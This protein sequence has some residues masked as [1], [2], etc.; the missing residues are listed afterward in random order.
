[1]ITNDNFQR[2]TQPAQS[3]LALWSSKCR[4][5]RE[6]LLLL[7]QTAVCD[8]TQSIPERMELASL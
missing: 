2:N 1:M 6:L 7:L 4:L 3:Y 8:T 5:T